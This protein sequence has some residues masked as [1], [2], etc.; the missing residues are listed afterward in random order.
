MLRSVAGEMY[1][2]KWRSKVLFNAVG[3]NAFASD[4]LP[5]EMSNYLIGVYTCIHVSGRPQTRYKSKEDKW[6]WCQ[7]RV[8]L[9]IVV[10]VSC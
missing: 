2:F 4:K 10:P 8:L 1:L 9:G 5:P 6:L 7:T 3:Q